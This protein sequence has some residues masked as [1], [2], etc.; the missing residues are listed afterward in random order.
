MRK[1]LLS[2]ACM[3]FMA[4]LV[5]AAEVTLVKYEK[6]TKTVTVKDS[7]G[8]EASYKLTDSTKVY[9][10]DKSGDKKEGKLANVEKMLGNEKLAGK[11]KFE[12]TTEK[13]VITEITTKG[14][15]KKS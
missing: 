15:K 11:A 14:G 5:I 8:K 13:G 9:Y 3:F 1:L 6:D 7:D 4:G 10:V 2:L 12:I